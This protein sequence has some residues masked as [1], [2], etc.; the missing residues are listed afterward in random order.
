M[1]SLHMRW[2][3]VIATARQEDGDITAVRGEMITDNK[4]NLAANAEIEVA[5]SN[6]L[7]AVLKTANMRNVNMIYY[8]LELCDLA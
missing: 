3:Y 8:W 7:Y 1:D 4:V 2:V 6:N 5:C